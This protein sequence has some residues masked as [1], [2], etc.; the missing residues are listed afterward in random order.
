MIAA[1]ANIRLGVRPPPELPPPLALERLLELASDLS[2][3]RLAPGFLGPAAA[4]LRGRE[5]G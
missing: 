3:V 5:A 2:R 1:T 4:R